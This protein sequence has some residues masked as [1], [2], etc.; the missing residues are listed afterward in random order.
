MSNATI[1]VSRWEI[2]ESDCVEALRGMAADSVDAC[3]TDVPYGLG[4][5]DPT[6][7]EIVGYLTAGGAMAHGDFMNK[8]WEIPPVAFWRELCRVLKPGA[9]VLCFAGTRTMDLIMLGIRAG[10]FE[11]RDSI[12]CAMPSE[13]AAVAAWVYASGFPKSLAV[14]KAIDR[15]NGDAREILSEVPGRW[16]YANNEK[17]GAAY[18]DES[19]SIDERGYLIRKT[20]APASDASAAF[21]GYGTALAPAWEPIILARKPLDGTVSHNATTHGT[22][23]LAIDAS[24][25]EG[26]WPKN[27]LLVHDPRCVRVGTKR[28]PTSDPRRS[29]GSTASV[30]LGF[31]LRDMAVGHPGYAGPDGLEDV[32]ACDCVPSCPCAILDAQSGDDHPSSLA[33]RADPRTSHAHP[34]PE[35]DSA[36]ALYAQGFKTEGTRV[37][38]DD[39]AASRFYSQFQYT[40]ADRFRFVAKASRSEREFGCEGLPART[41]KDAVGRDPD[42]VGAKNA[43]AGAGR[44]AGTTQEACSKCGESMTGGGG[45]QAAA[46]DAPCTDGGAHDPVVT[47]TQAGIRNIG[48]C[49]KPIALTRYLAGLL[50]P[51]AHADG[52]PLRI[53]CPYA[54][55]GSEMIGALRAGWD[56]AIGI[57]RISDDDE[58]AYVAIARARLA[59][60]DQVPASMDEADAVRESRTVAKET[61]VRQRSLFDTLEDEAAQASSLSLRGGAT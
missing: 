16:K 50:K 31:G 22:G 1:A 51:P 19:R 40:Q 8:K 3:L 6:V 15:A 54:G 20:T 9:H 55:T 12:G 33:G 29:D 45:R 28:V 47:G 56:E 25:V 48:P 34:Y 44:G 30:R 32:G 14:D 24:R 13:G 23:G 2:I 41:A 61:D 21:A 37:Y 4:S 27:V 35:S 52:S 5:R 59:R 42:S 11:L 53:L 18:G 58:K 7:G 17:S 57:Q 49:V 39:G 36:H 10:G 46:R 38:A 60:W 43:R 26:R